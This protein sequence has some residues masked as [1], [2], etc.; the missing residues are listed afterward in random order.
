M[1]E[2]R[3]AANVVIF[4]DLAVQTAANPRRIEG[5]H[6]STRRQSAN[7]VHTQEVEEGIGIQRV[8]KDPEAVTREIETKDVIAPEQAGHILQIVQEEKLDP[9]PERSRE[10]PPAV[11]NRINRRLIQKRAKSYQ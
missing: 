7:I 10:A 1:K 8:I 6:P 4:V 9:H 2:K 3:E 11:P 5:D